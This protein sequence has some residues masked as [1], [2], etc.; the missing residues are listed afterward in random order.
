MKWNTI[1]TVLTLAIAYV[2]LADTD[3]TLLTT[4]DL[5]DVTET[6]P[7]TT[8]SPSPTIVWLT[9]TLP[10]GGVATIQ[11][12]YSQIFTSFYSEV[13]SPSLGSVGLGSITGSVGQVRTYPVV[14]LSTSS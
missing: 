3:T 4:Q 6:T 11:S 9:T 2:T 8:R 5:D 7:T 12:H 14:T 1:T 13:A 10:N